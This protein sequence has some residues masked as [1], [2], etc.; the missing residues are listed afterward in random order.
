MS[1][2]E[3]TLW[4]TILGASIAAVV[5]YLLARRTSQETLRRDAEQRREAKLGLA[6]E[7]HVKLK[8][9]I[10]NL[11]TLLRMIE[12]QLSRPPSP[13][14]RPWMSVMPIVG[15]TSEDTVRFAAA[16]LVLFMEAQRADL[17]GDLQV[18]ARR[19]GVANVVLETYN[20]RR[21]ALKAKMP[22]P[23]SVSG[24]LGTTPLTREQVQ[25]LEPD[26]VALDSLILQLVPNLREDLKMGLRIAAEFG[27]V[28]QKHFDDRRFP[29]F[30]I[31]QEDVNAS[32]VGSA[33]VPTAAK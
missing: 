23:E 8:T 19:N 26:M 12:D 3:L 18:L 21:D 25:A 14:A 6:L 1:D 27:P 31:P 4:S 22:A 15:H 29:E 13:N 7:A 17:A 24:Q 9:I 20:E 5:S 2:G 28:L 30:R 33:T 11:G 32:E 10:D 16:E